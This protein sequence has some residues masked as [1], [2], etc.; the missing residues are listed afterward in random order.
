MSERHFLSYSSADGEEFVRRLA[1]ALANGE[2]PVEVWLDSDQVYGGQMWD[3]RLAE[4]IESCATLIFVMTADS[5]ARHSVC[6]SEWTHALDRRIPVIPLRADP[7]AKLPFRLN[8]LD[9][10]VFDDFDVGLQ[11]LRRTLAFLTTPE[12]VLHALRDAAIDA[13]RRSQRAR[14]D[15]ERAAI[16]REIDEIRREIEEQQRVVEAKEAAPR[17]RTSTDQA[18][19]AL[20]AEVALWVDRILTVQ[21][22]ETGG[23]RGQIYDPTIPPQTWTTAQSLA[24]ILVTPQAA[25]NREEI[26]AALAYL[27]RTRQ[28]GP[29]EGWSLYDDGGES[30]TEIA[31]WVA[32]AR[33]RSLAA[34]FVW[35][36]AE[37]EAEEGRL[38]RDLDWIV[39]RQHS[40]GGWCPTRH[41]TRRNTRTYS[42]LLAIW[43]LVEA[44]RTASMSADRRRQAVLQQGLR[45]LLNER[46]DTLGW[47]AN[48]NR[49]MQRDACLGLEAQALA[50]LLRAE[51]TA[52]RDRPSVLRGDRVLARAK[53]E[54]LG[55]EDFASRRIFLN[56]ALA[57]ADQRLQETHYHLEGSSFLWAPW[58]VAA[59]DELSRDGAADPAQTQRAREAKLELMARIYD[60]RD[61]LGYPGTYELAESLVCL[62]PVLFPPPG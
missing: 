37:T 20:A 24:G 22:P 33:M 55:L 59:L 41:L 39:G 45:W 52:D 18:E 6:K 26:R 32:L 47:V 4:G 46:S 19:S 15:A 58:S 60:K 29:H 13:E 8:S 49:R 48:P 27:E 2:P 53:S 43:S 61:K 3:E 12:G 23:I 30:V 25:R 34:G 35:S 21:D 14:S 10:I 5:V 56:D 38:R 36:A 54:F 44:D 9:Y 16:E 28:E 7:G 42:T 31:C 50:I 62:S 51:R 40:S 17:S 57:D 1:P 11:D